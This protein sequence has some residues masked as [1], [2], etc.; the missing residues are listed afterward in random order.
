LAIIDEFQGNKEKLQKFYNQK[1][2]VEFWYN[3]T[4]NSLLYK[5]I[6]L[7]TGQVKMSMKHQ[8]EIL[9]YSTKREIISISRNK[10]R[11]D[12]RFSTYKEYIET[13]REFSYKFSTIVEAYTSFITGN[14][15][16]D[17]TNEVLKELEKMHFIEEHHTLDSLKDDEINLFTDILLKLDENFNKKYLKPIEVNDE[18]G[19]ILQLPLTS[20]N[21]LLNS[22]P[23]LCGFFAAVRIYLKKES[24]EI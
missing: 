1:L 5:M 19:D 6:V 2:R 7:N 17:K 11:R 13:D 4:F 3:M 14:E 12:I 15:Q 16:V 9:N 23:F 10:Y 18:K 8:L 22:E 21:E 24:G 20:R